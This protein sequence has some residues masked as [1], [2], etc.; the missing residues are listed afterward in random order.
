[1][2]AD[3]DDLGRIGQDALSTWASQVGA[4]ANPSIRDR[5]GW[6]FLLQVPLQIG[7]KSGPLDRAPAEIACMIQV[8]A[9]R[10]GARS[11]P[12]KLSNWRRMVSDAIP[13]FVALVH[14]DQ[15]LR[16]SRAFLV[17]V[18][19][20][21]SA[22]V[23]RRLRELDQADPSTL[24]GQTLSIVAED[25]DELAELHGRALVER[26]RAVV[27][28][29]QHAYVEKKMSTFATLGYD[30]APRGVDVSIRIA[31]GPEFWNGVAELGVCL[32]K[33]FPG[34]VYAK[35]YD[36]RFGMRGTLADL[37][38]EDGPIEFSPSP[39]ATATLAL[40]EPGSSDGAM[41]D[42]LLYRS[43]ASFPFIPE[44]FD[45]F[46]VA[47]KWFSCVFQA[48]LPPHPKDFAPRLTFAPPLDGKVTLQEL[49]GIVATARLLGGPSDVPLLFTLSG[50]QDG[51]P[52]SV[53]LPLRR[54]PPDERLL[55]MIDEL[56]TARDVLKSFALPEQTTFV[57]R[58]VLG[59]EQVLA[60][61]NATLQP[62]TG[63]FRAPSTEE[64]AVGDSCGFAFEL[65]LRVA[66]LWL[67]AGISLW[68]T[69][70]NV[71]PTKW[72]YSVAIA[73]PECVCE[74][75]V[76]R[77]ADVATFDRA[78]LHERATARFVSAGFRELV[79]PSSGTSE[80]SSDET[81]AAGSGAE[82][83]AAPEAPGTQ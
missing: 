17:H 58:D 62:S 70:T 57:L 52:W 1:M 55:E 4:T 40:S 6:D 81:S 3:P 79:C 46:R 29:T 78:G 45:L 80:T 9:T 28:P 69:V 35:A 71:Q 66:D 27:T 33:T 61:L 38:P 39:V 15:D 2:D 82:D 43:S 7:P 11:V 75:Q 60:L 50:V 23:L 5:H 16:P 49:D 36:Q 72:G 21:W 77:H 64:V 25:R 41:F 12:I 18:D 48:K 19:E 13:W 83:S 73:R 22:K 76:V 42:C 24:S 31:D 30:D 47:G 53:P 65:R 59:Q 32:R 8:K 26:I 10:T 68:G 44:E 74:R 67:V 20:A 63:E 56:R 54:S 14:L 34:Q 51:V 37:S